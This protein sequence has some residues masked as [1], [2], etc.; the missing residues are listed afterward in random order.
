MLLGTIV[1]AV[2]IGTDK[3][4]PFFL[5]DSRL[6]TEY[7]F[8]G[9]PV[10]IQLAAA[11]EMCVFA[12]G[13]S[14]VLMVVLFTF[15][16]TVSAEVYL[17]ALWIFLADAET[18]RLLMLVIAQRS[19][20][21]GPLVSLTRVVYGAR[22]A[23]LI[24]LF[25]SGLYAVGIG[26]ER[27]QMGYLLAVLFGAVLAVLMPI[28]IDRFQSSFILQAGY[29]DITMIV[30][31]ALIG[32]NCVDYLVAARLKEDVSYAFVGIGLTAAAGAWVWLWDTRPLGWGMGGALFFAL[33]AFLSVERLHKIYIWK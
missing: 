4:L 1:L 23:G 17:I 28:S 6:Y 9:A 18:L 22:F 11:L 10:G 24:A 27:P 13:V 33:C 15:Q 7:F 31:A 32:I 14:A 29:R 30:S 25:V 8:F 12:L 5:A 2:R 21:I 26:H 20:S 16:K 19:T 3:R